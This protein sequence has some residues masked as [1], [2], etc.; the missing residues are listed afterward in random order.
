MAKTQFTLKNYFKE[1]KK[2]SIFVIIL[3]I[4]GAAAG[5]WFAFRKP[6]QYTAVSTI[7]VY[8]NTIENGTPISPYKQ[9]A[10]LIS[11][12]KLIMEADDTLKDEDF[13]QY[14][15]KET[16]TGVFQIEATADTEQKAI[17]VTKNVMNNVSGV[18]ENTYDDSENY[19][20]K[21]LDEAT[22]ATPTVTIKSRIISIAVAIAGALILAMIVV[23]VKF[24]YQAEK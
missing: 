18:I 9:I 5:T 24:D 16:N 17:D 20:V 11:S 7:S 22:T 13:S 1:L 15:V 14:E 6:T 10:A 2:C 8:N 4:I 23:F 21:I 19:R 12:K 3:V